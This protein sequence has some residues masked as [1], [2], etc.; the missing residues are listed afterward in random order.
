[1]RRGLAVL[2]VVAVVGIGAFAASAWVGSGDDAP[3]PTT[4]APKPLLRLRVIFPE[5]FSVA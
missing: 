1:M 5:G 4:T 3:P 2:I